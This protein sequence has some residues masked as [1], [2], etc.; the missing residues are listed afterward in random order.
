MIFF[1]R[2]T[3][4]LA[5]LTIAVNPLFL[6][7]CLCNEMLRRLLLKLYP[8]FTYIGN[9]TV[10][11]VTQAIKK[12]YVGPFDVTANAKGVYHAIFTH[13]CPYNSKRRRFHYFYQDTKQTCPSML[14]AASDVSDMYAKLAQMVERRLAV[15][16]NKTNAEQEQEVEKQ[17]PDRVYQ[18]IEEE[19]KE[20]TEKKEEG[21]TSNCL[22]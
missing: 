5:W 7:Q 11:A 14:I 22:C 4:V 21:S 16:R 10:D 19:N 8:N 17:I 3:A 12:S 20:R 18:N 15:C 6:N 13:S 2:R 1:P 9:T